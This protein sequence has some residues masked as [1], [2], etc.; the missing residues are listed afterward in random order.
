[1]FLQSEHQNNS[2]Q[3]SHQLISHPPGNN[4]QAKSNIIFPASGI[5]A[6]R[7]FRHQRLKNGGT[8]NRET[9]YQQLLPYTLGST[10]LVSRMVVARSLLLLAH[11]S[12]VS[13]RV[14][15]VEC[16]STPS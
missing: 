16:E 3:K 5:T 10:G 15:S 14:L 13:C 4:Q 6:S 2:S 1:M 11:R 9:K 7:P 8:E 12:G